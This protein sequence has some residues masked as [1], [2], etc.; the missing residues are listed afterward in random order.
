[1]IIFKDETLKVAVP[2]RIKH[3][4]VKACMHARGSSGVLW[5]R[6]PVLTQS[7]QEGRA[8]K[9]IGLTCIGAANVHRDH[10]AALPRRVL[11]LK[12]ELRCRV[13]YLTRMRGHHR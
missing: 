3:M 11:N 12:P 5:A 6:W 7:D 1:M 10:A 8:P 4:E 2:M 13:F 9:A